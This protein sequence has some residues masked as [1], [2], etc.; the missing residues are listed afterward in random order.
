MARIAFN[1][2]NSA[3]DEFTRLLVNGTII[4]ELKAIKLTT[5]Y[6][7]TTP[8]AANTGEKDGNTVIGL[9]PAAGSKLLKGDAREFY[10]DRLS[11]ASELTRKAVNL[12]SADALTPANRDAFALTCVKA[13]WDKFVA[14]DVVFKEDKTEG[15]V[16]AYVYTIKADNKV[17]NGEFT[18]TSGDQ[19]LQSFSENLGGFDAPAA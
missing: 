13:V 10:Y 16:V 4:P 15:E 5:D 9:T 6:T 18:I 19:T 14:A 3:D 17:F 12:K 11:I 2:A 8:A 7:V 1:P